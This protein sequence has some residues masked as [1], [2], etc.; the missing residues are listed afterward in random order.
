MD[1]QGEVNMNQ[2]GEVFQEV[3]INTNKKQKEHFFKIADTDNDFMINK[4]E[5]ENVLEKYDDNKSLTEN[6]LGLNPKQNRNKMEY[7]FRLS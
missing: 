4:M 5:L 2:L 6:L 1:A 3:G 7:V